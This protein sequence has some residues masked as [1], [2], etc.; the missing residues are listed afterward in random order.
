MGT[1][2]YLAKSMGWKRTL[3]SN[4]GVSNSL[5][6]HLVA[7]EESNLRLRYNELTHQI[8]FSES[9]E[10]ENWQ[11]SNDFIEGR[12]KLDILKMNL[13]GEEFMNFMKYIPPRYNPVEEF[14]SSLP[15]WDKVERFPL[16]IDTLELKPGIDKKMPAR[17][18][19][20]WMIGVINGLHNR[21]AFGND[22]SIS[23]NEN[24]LILI[25]PQGIG[26]TRWMR[27]LMPDGWHQLMA[28]KLSFNFDDKDDKLLSCEKAIICMDEMAPVLNRKATNE[29]LKGFLSQRTFNIRVAYGRYNNVFHKIASFIG[30]SNENEL[31]TDPTASRRFWPID[32][33]SAD[34]NHT[35][36]M[37]QL[38][39]QCYHF[40]KEGERHWLSSEEQQELNNY[41]T[42]FTNVH[43]YEEYI[44]R[45]IEHGEELLTGTQISE[46]INERLNNNNAVN[47]RQLGIYMKKAGYENASRWVNGKTNRVYEV[48]LLPESEM[49]EFRVL[50]AKHIAKLKRLKK[51]AAE[52][53]EDL[54]NVELL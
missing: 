25:G 46:Y 40:W 18:L 15:I 54:P 5:N 49:G 37:G 50:D 26:K 28:E 27:K 36:D 38:W 11:I 42:E 7:M 43:P 1:L 3:K 9:P 44:A 19:R 35:I 33:V 20:R 24:L 30:T 6:G 53:E 29:Q 12:I 10:E 48:T 32:I 22:P 52:K 13:K 14:L 8:H 2:V 16:L 39:A 23:P 45:F 51:Q 31:I 4:L 34:Y 17:L 21:P 41:N 47:P